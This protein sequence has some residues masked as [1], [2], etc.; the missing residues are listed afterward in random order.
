M[1]WNLVIE[2]YELILELVQDF[3]ILVF[4]TLMNHNT[5]FIRDSYQPLWWALVYD[6]F[7]DSAL[8]SLSILRLYR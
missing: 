2:L 4:L 1:T 5:I 6:I 7:N 8:E 3:E